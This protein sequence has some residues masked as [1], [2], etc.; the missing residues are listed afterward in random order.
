M[1]KRLL[2]HALAAVLILAL[3]KQFDRP[4]KNDSND[5]SRH[6]STQFPI[7]D[8]V[9]AILTVA[10]YDCHSNNTRYP[11]YAEFQPIAGMMDEHV[12]HGKKA[13]NFSEF[14]SYRPRKQFHKMEEVAELVRD[15]LMPIADYLKMHDDA[16]LTEAQRQTIYAWV[17][18]THDSMRSFY[19]PDSL[20][21]RRRQ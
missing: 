5:Q 2:V 1:I 13:L 7:P 21:A 6:F 14:A 8:S 20:K 18:A 16:V 12:V 9:Q 4:V 15:S 11:W 19:P 3:A 17:S 10:C